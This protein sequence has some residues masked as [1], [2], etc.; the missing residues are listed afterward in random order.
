MEMAEIVATL[1]AK[2]E[3]CE[4]LAEKEDKKAYGKRLNV[5]YGCGMAAGIIRKMA[6]EMDMKEASKIDEAEQ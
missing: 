1:F 5:I 6:V 4:L 3:E 2:A